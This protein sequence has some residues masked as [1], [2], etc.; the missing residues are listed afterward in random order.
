MSSKYSDVLLFVGLVLMFV[1]VVV[2]MPL[3]MLGVIPTS[4]TLAI[5]NEGSFVLGLLLS[6]SPLVD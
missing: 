6:L 4:S 2:M 1:P 3:A 5:V